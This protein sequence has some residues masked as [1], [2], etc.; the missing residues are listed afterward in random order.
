MCRFLSLL[1]VLCAMP[2]SSIFQGTCLKK[3]APPGVLVLSPG[4]SLVLSCDGDVRVDGAKVKVAKRPSNDEDSSSET[5]TGNGAFIKTD[6]NSLTDNS[7][8]EGIQSAGHASSS[9]S[10]TTTS[11]SSSSFPR[12]QEVQPTSTPLKGEDVDGSEGRRDVKGKTKWKWN[13]KTV[14]RGHWDWDGFT[15][16]RRRTQLSV[17]SVRLK[18]SGNYTCQH[19][20]RETFSLK[21]I[22]ADPP[23]VPSLSC[24][25]RSPSSK[26]RCDWTPQKPLTLRPSCY[27]FIN[28]RH[29]DRF[30]RVQCSFSSQWSRCWCVLE[31]NED[32]LRTRHMAYLCVTNMA[33][34]ATSTILPFYPLNILKP[35]PPSAV[36]VRQE[37]G[38]ET[39]MT[40]NWAYPVSWK[41][42]DNYYELIYEL[43]Y[44]AVGSSSSSMQLMLIK[45]RRFFTI[46]DAMPGVEYMIQVRTQDEYDGLWSNWSAPVYGSSWTDAPTLSMLFMTWTLERERK[47]INHNQQDVLRCTRL[48]KYY[49][50]YMCI[51]SQSSCLISDS[52]TQEPMA[53]LNEDLMTITFP[54][55]EGSGTDVPSEDTKKNS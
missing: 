45:G 42:Q 5:Q 15:T 41:S 30:H 11:S 38:H 40:V 49:D 43:K 18:D 27:L 22:V 52:R 44:Q 55:Y 54:E 21:V 10:S 17:T 7:H 50:I 16:G 6:R 12:H 14:G 35:D 1:W 3:E 39:R 36:S 28:K 33:G 47:R 29:S 48:I 51:I 34:N 46:T 53:L 24:S 32:E 8:E 13:G 9:S 2:V 23:E 25:K 37:M 20:D 19:R 26:I 4:S 31:H